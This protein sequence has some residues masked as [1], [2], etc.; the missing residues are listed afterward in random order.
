M[1]SCGMSCMRRDK[2][3]IVEREGEAK[4]HHL[5]GASSSSGFKR[6]QAD[7]A[8]INVFLEYARALTKDKKFKEALSVI[9]LCCQMASLST[10]VIQEFGAELIDFYSVHIGKGSFHTDPWSAVSAQRCWWTRSP[11]VP[12]GTRC[13][14]SASSGTS[15]A[16][17]RN[18]APPTSPLTPTP[19]TRSPT[20]S[21]PSWSAS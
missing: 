19:W 8:S 5:P 21:S 7:N 11:L 2:R 18:V 13:A 9:S 14:R 16:R 10:D 15:A 17:A 4:T 6:I 1:G 12:A 3:V 20:S